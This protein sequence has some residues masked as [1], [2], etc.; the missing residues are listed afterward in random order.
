MGLLGAYYQAHRASRS[1]AGT[2]RVRV[3]EPAKIASPLDRLWPDA[4]PPAGCAIPISA[5][6]QKT[7]A[8][9]PALRWAKVSAG[10]SARHLRTHRRSD[11]PNVA[12]QIPGWHRTMSFTVSNQRSRSGSRYCGMNST[13]LSLSRRISRREFREA[14][15]PASGSGWRWAP[16]RAGRRP[17][18]P[19]VPGNSRASSSASL[20]LFRNERKPLSSNA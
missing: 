9:R 12:A 4:G 2:T 3:A 11:P 20:V 5:A 17:R 19:A 8:A 10:A 1:H 7:S 13:R 14:P 15:P 6:W 18:W 16:G